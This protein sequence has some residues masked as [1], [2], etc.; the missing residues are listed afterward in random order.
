MFTEKGWI[1]KKVKLFLALLALSLQK[2]E[3]GGEREEKIKRLFQLESFRDYPDM[4]YTRN[5]Q[6]FLESYEITTA[7]LGRHLE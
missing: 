2:T 6:N 3:G 7:P 5:L 1:V 4:G